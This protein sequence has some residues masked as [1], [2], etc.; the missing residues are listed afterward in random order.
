DVPIVAPGRHDR[1][2]ASCPRRPPLPAW[3]C[4]RPAT[5]PE[6]ISKRSVTARDISDLEVEAFL[7]ELQVLLPIEPVELRG[8]VGDVLLHLVEIHEQI[9]GEDLLAE[10]ALVERPLED[11]LVDL[12][13]LRERELRG[14][15]LEPDGL[16]AHLSLEPRERSVRDLGVIEGQ[17]RQI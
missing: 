3:R 9:H 2:T 16:V 5:E 15:E 4:V 12:L 14:Q 11:R 17:R 6:A 10:V 13:E 7:L 1:P 8:P